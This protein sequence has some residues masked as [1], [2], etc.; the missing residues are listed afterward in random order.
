MYEKLFT[1][2]KAELTTAF[3][4]QQAKAIGLDMDRFH[5]DIN[6]PCS[7]GA[8]CRGSKGRAGE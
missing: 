2:E 5:K 1:G 4:D 8:R 7:E 6:D 3:I